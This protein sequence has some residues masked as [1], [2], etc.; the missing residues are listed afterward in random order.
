[1]SRPLKIPVDNGVNSWDSLMNDDLDILFS[2][3]LPIHESA[4]LTESNVQS[5]F[6]AASYDRCIV[7]V[8]HSIVGHTPYWSDGTAWIPVKG[9]RQPQTNLTA[10]TTQ[11]RGD[12]RVRYTGAGSVDYDFLPAAQWAGR[13][14]EIRN[15]SGAAINLDPDGSET[16]NGGG[17]GSPLSLAVGS[18]ARVYSTGSALFADIA[19]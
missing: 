2:G 3:P 15:D 10:T 5:T 7:W 14:V 9:V 19:L 13:T 11:V 12:V 6:P 1:M 8:N 16:I 18:T 17:A 4:S